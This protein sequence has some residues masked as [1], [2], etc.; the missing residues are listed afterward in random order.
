[1]ERHAHDP[2]LEALKLRVLVLLTALPNDLAHITAAKRFQRIK[3]HIERQSGYGQAVCS[4]INSS[5][6]FGSA[7]IPVSTSGGCELACIQAHDCSTA[8]TKDVASWRP[9]VPV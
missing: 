9:D 6:K 1:V 4:R 3:Q 5:T 8:Y 7:P 2:G